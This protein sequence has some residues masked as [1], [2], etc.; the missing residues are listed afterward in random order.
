M[1]GPIYIKISDSSWLLEIPSLLCCYNMKL[2]AINLSQLGYLMW[3][4]YLN[5]ISAHFVVLFSDAY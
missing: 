4:L 3:F 2:D 5:M 1:L